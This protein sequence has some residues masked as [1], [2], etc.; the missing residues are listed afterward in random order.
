MLQISN[1]FKTRIL[2]S[3]SFIDIFHRGA[4]LLFDGARPPTADGP[5]PAPV[6]MITQD[7]NAWAPPDI[8]F[9]LQ[10]QH[11]GP[12]IFNVG[13][14]KLRA[15]ANTPLMKWA[16]LVGPVADN[17]VVNYDL[18]R[19]DF[20]VGLI[21]TPGPELLLPKLAFTTGEALAVGAFTYT[22]PPVV[23]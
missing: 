18:P 5:A 6:A 3:E 2:G 23:P 14:W 11:A 15:S 22:F 12:Y 10:F 4:I 1:G 21:G 20:D 8:G 13:D 19:I 9:G 17:G 16:R 7:G